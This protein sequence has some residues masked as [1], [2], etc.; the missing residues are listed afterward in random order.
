[1]GEAEPGQGEQI[2]G[3]HLKN[4]EEVVVVE[5]GMQVDPL[6]LQERPEE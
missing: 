2:K 1:V 6:G 3:S 5:A 4:V